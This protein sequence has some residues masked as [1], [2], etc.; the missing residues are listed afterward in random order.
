MNAGFEDCVILDE[1]FDKYSNNNNINNIELIF[2]EFS[3]KRQPSC[4][5]LSLLSLQNYVEMRSL[6]GK[7]W[8]LYKKKFE[9][10]L[11]T[12][13]PSI[14]KPIYSMVS[15]SRTP[16]NEAMERA[17]KQDKYLGIGFGLL[18]TITTIS[19]CYLAKKYIDSQNDKNHNNSKL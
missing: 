9:G 11:N 12:L 7:K 3:N 14:W 2:N 16:Y 6:T 17:K 15:F 19:C 10:I 4:D 5:A 8:F 13:V 18:T 1:L